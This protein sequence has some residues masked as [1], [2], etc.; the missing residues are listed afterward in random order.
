MPRI[1]QSKHSLHEDLLAAVADARTYGELAAI[2]AY[3]F[4]HLG[5]RFL[6]DVHD[7]IKIRRRPAVARAG[8]PVFR[9]A[10]TSI[11]FRV[12]RVD[13]AWTRDRS[14]LT[15]ERPASTELASDALNTY[16]AVRHAVRATYAQIEIHRQGLAERKARIVQV[17][18]AR[19]RLA[20]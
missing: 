11:A 1:S 6:R 19:R 5:G 13:P 17:L 15:V 7:A 2:E 12:V 16:D 4:E 20:P 10:R 9:A 18:A 8:W 14:Q 3:A